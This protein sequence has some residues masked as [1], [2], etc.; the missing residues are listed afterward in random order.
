MKIKLMARVIGENESS[1]LG[2]FDT[3]DEAL[4]W[5][6]DE[7]ADGGAREEVL[8]YAAMPNGECMVLGTDDVW[9]SDSPESCGHVAGGAR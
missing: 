3:L 5:V 8:L 4:I 1:E 9:R 7:E 2:E 6:K